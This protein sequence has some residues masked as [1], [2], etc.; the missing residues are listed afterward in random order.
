MSTLSSTTCRFQEKLAAYQ[1]LIAQSMY[2]K[3][4]DSGRGTLLHLCDDVIQQEESFR[5]DQFFK[6]VVCPSY[7]SL[8]A[9]NGFY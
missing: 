2:D 8:V 5:V 1:N 7:L 9:T 3:L 6:S 4:L